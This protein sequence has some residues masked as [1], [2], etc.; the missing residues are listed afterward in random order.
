MEFA[1]EWKTRI[2]FWVGAICVGL[3]AYMFA[4]GSEY[5]NVFHHIIINL[6]PLLSLILA[7]AGFALAVAV[8]R[9][10]FVGSQGSGIPQTIAALELR[11]MSAR[12]KLLSLRI[13]LGKIPL[14]LLG[15][16]SGAST[17]REGPTVQIGAAIMHTLG[18]WAR[19]PS[20]D[21]E[22]GLILAG[23]AAG[24]AAA[25]NTPLAG[26]VFAIEELSRSFEQR[27][28]GTILI[29]VLIAGV[30]S[31]SLQG[32]YT[33]FGTIHSTLNFK[34]EW[35]AVFACGVSGG[36]FGGLFSRFLIA[37]SRGLPGRIGV[38]MRERPVLFAAG[39]GFVLA[40][41]GLAS[42]NTIYGTGYHEAR[43]ILDGNSTVPDSFGI[44]KM[45]ATLISY[46]SGIPGG[47]F[48]PSL[49]IGAGMGLNLTHI[50]PFASVGAVVLLGMVGYFAG[51]IQAPI[52]AFI[53][54]MEMTDNHDMV[55]PLMATAFLAMVTSRLICRESL[56]QAL[57][58]NFIKQFEPG[59][60]HTNKKNH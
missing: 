50:L 46:F 42:D 1:H 31:L 13:A 23:G 59:K 53:I 37:G 57:A 18:R 45:A 30:T 49:A 39:C 21:L 56:Y 35:I 29:A 2:V 48:S 12:D 27:T 60:E 20:H 16:L 15:L 38:L 3:A 26:I 17:G 19:F 41:L 51:V 36:L 44:L 28:S 6:S 55:L 32:N 54:V 14:T 22:R 34:V 5:A 47:I 10:F 9:K 24:V 52:T 40:L 25:F 43:Q 11:D 8:T 33:Y 58:H 7:P 4:V